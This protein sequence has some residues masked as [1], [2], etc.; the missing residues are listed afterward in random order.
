MKGKLRFIML[1]ALAV[2][3]A[4]L[5]AGCGGD[6]GDNGSSA[7]T[8]TAASSEPLKIGASLPLTGDFAEPGVAAQQGYKIWQ[9]LVNKDGGLLGRQVELIIKDDQSDQ[10]VIVSDYNALIQKEKVDLLLGTFSSL[11]NLPASAVAERNKMLFVEPAGGSPEMFSRGFKYL[12]FA[13]QATSQHQ[14]DLFAEWVTGL[15]DDEKPKTAAYVIADDPFGGPVAE[16]IKEKLEAAGVETVYS[17]VYPPET[18]NFDAAAAAV[19]SKKPDVIAQGSAGLADGV[20]L[21]RS[22]I[23]V[24]YSPKQMFQAST[25]SFADQ[26]SDAIGIKNTEGVFYAVS[27]HVD[28]PTPGN[29]EFLAAYKAKYD[30]DPPE[31]AADGYAAAQVLQKA[32]EEVGEIDQTKLADWLRENEVDTIL[33]PLSWDETGAP[34]Q[35]FLLAQWQN[36]DEEIVLP[37]DAATSDTIVNPKPAW[38]N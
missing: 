19:A 7:G 27:Y 2:A 32:V 13:Q 1:L 25:P 6:D 17:K 26:Y 23:K 9:E 8:D 21:I 22:L 14:A 18:V 12:F 31:D 34:E 38:S 10:N 33:G 15:P 36:G 11:L 5:A 37:E 4:A 20:N 16:G 28:S 30:T 35:A 29:E 3:A 24:G